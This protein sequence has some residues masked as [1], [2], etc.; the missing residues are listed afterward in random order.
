MKAI[1]KHCNI[2]ND[3]KKFFGNNYSEFENNDIYK[4]AILTPIT[5]IGELVK[6]LTVDFCKNVL[7]EVI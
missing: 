5:Q 4:N 3:T 1:I 7:D 6:K 2:I